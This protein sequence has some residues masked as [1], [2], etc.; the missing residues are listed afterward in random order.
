M[1]SG[2]SVRL[3]P[4]RLEDAFAD[5]TWRQDPEL[6][7][8]DASVP[9]DESFREYERGYTWELEHPARHR[10]RLAIETAE[11]KHIGNIAYFDID[12]TS[13]AAQL[14]IMIGDRSYWGKGFGTEAVKLALRRM[15]NDEGLEAAYLRTLDWNTR[16][17][18]AFTRAGFRPAGELKEGRHNFI[19][20]RIT[21]ADWCQN[22]K[23]ESGCS[24]D[25]DGRRG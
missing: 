13:K 14:G 20:M 8:L 22:N 12:R 7:E 2:E 9:L 18:R 4:K 25:T 21:R 6:A 17:Q 10:Q 16:A 1:L 24:R 11:G 3:R 5:Y 15:F 19:I 23:K